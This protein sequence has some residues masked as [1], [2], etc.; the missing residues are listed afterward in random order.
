MQAGHL[1]RAK[2]STEAT[3]E[4]ALH[5]VMICT[6]NA[7]INRNRQIGPRLVSGSRCMRLNH[8]RFVAR[9]TFC[10]RE[11]DNDVRSP[12]RSVI[13]PDLSPVSADHGLCEGQAHPA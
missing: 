1:L 4:A 3:T 7:K 2:R 5:I 6:D 10:I 13:G 12:S 9:G 11:V 8:G